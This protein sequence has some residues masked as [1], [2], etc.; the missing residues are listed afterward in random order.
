MQKCLAILI[1][2]GMMLA[3]PVRSLAQ[4]SCPP[5][6]LRPGD[7]S[8]TLQVD[9]RNRSYDL[10]IPASVTSGAAV[11]LVVDIHGYTS[12]KSQQAQLSQFK[13][14]S[15]RNNFIVAYP[16]GIRNQWNAGDAVFLGDPNIDDVG[17]IRALV[18][19]VAKRVRVDRSRV[20][21]TGLSNGSFLTHRLACEASDV[22]A[23]I[24]G[25]SGGL[26]FRNFNNCQP[27]RPISV[28]MYHG[29]NDSIVPYNGGGAAGFRPIRDTFEFWARTNRCSGSPQVSTSGQNM[30]ETY[31]NCAAG[32]QVSLASLVSTHTGIYRVQAVN[33]SS[34][35]WAIFQKSQLPNPPVDQGGAPT[36]DNCGS[37]GGNAGGNNGGGNGCAGPPATPVGLQATNNARNA[38]VLSWNPVDGAVSYTV[39]RFTGLTWAVVGES[40]APNLTVELNGLQLVRVRSN[41]TCGSSS[42]SSYIGVR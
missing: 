16:Q 28:A 13:T 34:N 19:D 22:F 6:Q 37:A 8:M 40:A 29:L 36:A 30:I 15:N 33:A 41:N 26:Q 25:M 10:H 14:L 24:A 1:T 23:A 20:Y 32:T 38:F 12:N 18:A 2:I 9:G 42:Y 21:A 39:Q 35:A 5:N 31:T 27:V 11:P 4:G 7:Y 17:F 3:T